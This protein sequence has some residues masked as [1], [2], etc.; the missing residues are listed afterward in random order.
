MYQEHPI[1][2]IWDE[3]S[4]MDANVSGILTR[5]GFRPRSMGAAEVARY[6]KSNGFGPCVLCMHRRELPDIEMIRTLKQHY[7]AKIYLVLRVD[8]ADLD[9][10]V[11]AIKCGVDDVI[12]DGAGQQS[13]WEKIAGL[14]KLRLLKNDS[15]VFVD[16]TSQ[17]LLALVERVG[18][19]E[20]TALMNGPTG[21][22]KEVLARLTHDF[23]PR[24]DGPFV[25]VNCAALPEAL[26]ESLLFGHAKGA[27]TGATRSTE[28]F[29][30]QAQGGTLFLDEI[31]ELTLP[32]QAKLLRAIQEKEVLPVGSSETQHVDVRII[33]ATNR[34]L[35]AG[36]RAG[37]FREDLYFRVSTFRINVPGLSSRLDDILPLAN[38]FLVKHGREDRTLQLSPE[39]SAKLLAYSWPGNVRELENVVQRAIVLSGDGVISANHLVFDEPADHELYIGEP[40]GMPASLMNPSHTPSYAGASSAMQGAAN[41][42]HPLDIGYGQRDRW[43]DTQGA[44]TN[45]FSAHMAAQSGFES[46]PEETSDSTTGLQ[47]A[48]DAN[49]FRIIVDT[50]K[51]T[52]TRQEAADMLGISQRTLRYKI[53]R[54]RER[55]IQ[56]PKRRSA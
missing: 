9:S 15:Y 25:P 56:I 50:I 33:A 45:P 7:G 12:A 47:G 42:V 17:H 49:E 4:P 40:S 5:A 38:Y 26:A 37:Y 51:N 24:R 30:S 53:A 3:S 39:A 43:H 52:R 18:A 31:G 20:V 41:N 34:D 55:G 54:M 35:R 16:E 11:E 28:G 14:A 27:F 1:D 19:A 44:P 48:M 46:L 10:T 6:V 32:L 22:G 13:K 8:P 36:I 2:L 29:F 23:S 21:S